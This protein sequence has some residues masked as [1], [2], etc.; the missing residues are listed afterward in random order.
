MPG[1]TIRDVPEGTYKKLLARAQRHNRSVEDEVLHVLQH[2]LPTEKPK[3]VVEILREER[4]R[5]PTL[6]VDLE[7]VKRDMREGLP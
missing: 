3:D 1:I 2:T 7:S 5:T 6:N 4:Q